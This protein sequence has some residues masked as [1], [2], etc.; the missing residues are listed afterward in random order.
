MV[1]DVKKPKQ[2]Q[3]FSQDGFPNILV[4]VIHISS[5]IVY[6]V[7]IYGILVCGIYIS[8]ILGKFIIFFWV[9][10]YNIPVSVRLC[11]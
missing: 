8:N 2:K 4:G 9:N 10:M 3:I 7:H 11:L 6:S 1:L 5:N